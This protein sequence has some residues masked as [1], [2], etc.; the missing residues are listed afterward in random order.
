M[1][2][3][4][5]SKFQKAVSL[6]QNNDQ[7]KWIG[8][9]IIVLGFWYIHL[10]EVFVLINMH[11]KVWTRSDLKPLLHQHITNAYEVIFPWLM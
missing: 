9:V 4:H 10:R 6:I 7:P 5:A 11:S 8:S 3:I 1:L 2:L